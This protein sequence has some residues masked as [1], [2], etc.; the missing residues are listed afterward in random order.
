MFAHQISLRK[1]G[2]CVS[3]LALAVLGTLPGYSSQAYVSLCC[4]AAGSVSAFNSGTNQLGGTFFTLPGAADMVLSPDGNNAYVATGSTAQADVSAGGVNTLGVYQLSTGKLLRAIP[5]PASPTEIVL[6]PAGDHVYAVA[7]QPTTGV[8]GVI[9]VDLAAG[10]TS[11]APLPAS[12][13][14]DL[15]PIAI[16]RDGKTLYAGSA[17]RPV[18]TTLDTATLA[19]T[20]SITLT[21]TAGPAP[22]AITPDGKKLAV[23]VAGSG[24]P[25]LDIVDL[26]T[27]TAAAVPLS[28]TAFPFGVALSPDGA[29]AYVN[30]SSVLA[31]NLASASVVASTSTGFADPYRIAITPDGASLYAASLHGVTDVLA[32]SSLAITGTLKTLA[33]AFQI[34]FTPQGGGYVLNENG[35]AAM[36]IDT[37]AMK[38]VRAVAAGDDP[39]KLAASANPAEAF[40]LN[41]GSGTLEVIRRP[42]SPAT[43][44]PV[45]I[46]GGLMDMT[47]LGNTLYALSI[48][49]LHTV[50]PVTLQ[51]SH[52]IPV[53]VPNPVFDGTEGTVAASPVA[54]YLFMPYFSIDE[55][56]VTGGGLLI[57]NTQTGAAPAISSGVYVGGPVVT[58]P[59]GSHVYVAAS[60][61]FSGPASTLLSFDIGAQTLAGTS[62]LGS[63]NYAAI[64]ISKDGNTLYC[65]DQG[66]KVDFVDTAS[67]HVTASIPAGVAP[68]GI[69]VNAAGTQAIVTDSQS[70]SVTV[71]DLT[72]QQVA[73]TISLPT[74]S[75]G[76]A[77]LN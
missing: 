14:F 46:G 38:A 4:G 41:G 40:V 26:A 47:F 59:D 7:V 43:V 1:P 27:E 67:L 77:Y 71:L 11:V 45:P 13:P 75:L 69:A 42:A 53:P 60:V 29:T 62:T 25:A 34:A 48:L 31:V 50:D 52:L 58:S 51:V 6:S 10:T 66:G 73:G 30:G 63:A 20:G 9:S 72:N 70:R 76:A 61:L 68:R 3:L 32:T 23:I 8:H 36:L 19:V 2:T 18:L 57:Y 21:G 15:L 39:A 28:T 44:V 17:N 37:S 12:P 74:S 49:G 33:G 64:A 55:E 24:G 5:L 65:V 35:S 54:P 22:P 16:S 56:G